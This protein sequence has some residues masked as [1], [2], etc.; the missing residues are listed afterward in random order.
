P[1]GWPRLLAGL[2]WRYLD[3]R[4]GFARLLRQG[5]GQIKGRKACERGG[6]EQK[7]ARSDDTGGRHGTKPRYD[8]SGTSQRTRSHLLALQPPDEAECLYSPTDIFACDHG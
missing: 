4:H 7:T 1:A 2:G 8:V 6:S 3:R 5:Q